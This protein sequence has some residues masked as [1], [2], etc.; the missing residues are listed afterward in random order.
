M[1]SS[2][3]R[4]KSFPDLDEVHI[5][6][7]PLCVGITWCRMAD[8]S[9]CSLSVSSSHFFLTW[10]ASS[11]CSCLLHLSLCYSTECCMVEAT[12]AA[13]AN[14]WRKSGNFAVWSKFSDEAKL[15]KDCRSVLDKNLNL[16]HHIFS[17]I[18]L[19]GWWILSL[20]LCA[21]L[22]LPSMCLDSFSFL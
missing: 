19:V 12:V 16:M 6:I 2:F 1:L 21:Y 8:I 14:N 9:L 18:I 11:C 20:C 4:C 7:F 22:G 17:S 15:F 5:N 10:I 13:H 3:C